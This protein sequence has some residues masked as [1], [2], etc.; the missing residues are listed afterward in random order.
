MGVALPCVVTGLDAHIKCVSQLDVGV[1]ELALQRY[2]FGVTPVSAAV[3]A[4]QQKLADVFLEL[5][6]IPKPVLIK[7][8]LPGSSAVKTASN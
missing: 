2:Q 4:E 7:D 8:A 6:L 5:R 3:A 1:V